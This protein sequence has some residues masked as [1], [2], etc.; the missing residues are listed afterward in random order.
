MTFELQILDYLQT[1]HTPLL[2]QIMIGA[3]TLG[4]TGI[5]W[6]TLTLILLIIP[7]TRSVGKVLVLSLIIEI[8]LVNLVLKPM[9]HR[10][11][12]FDANPMV[13]LLID[14]PQDYSFPSGHTGMAFTIVSGLCLMHRKDL[15]GVACVL[16]TVI[17][18]SRMYLYVHYPT[19]VL[20][21]IIIG[22]L[23][24]YAG[25]RLYQYIDS[26][27]KHKNETDIDNAQEDGQIIDR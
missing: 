10:Q 23:S 26:R 21:G 1:L 7:K 19:D 17:A 16:A 2:N 9:I 13:H 5:L 27:M 11:R 12:P 14:P 20:G 3:S 18:F 24:G 25:F 22:L 6:I 8:V 15:G 4:N